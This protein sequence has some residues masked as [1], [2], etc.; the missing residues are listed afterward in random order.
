MTGEEFREWLTLMKAQGFNKE[1]C[2]EL[3]GRKPQW[4]SIS[5]D[6][7]TDKMAALACAAVLHGIEPFTTAAPV[8]LPR[9]KSSGRGRL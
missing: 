5:Q 9:R 3:L 2:A 6:T 7:G 8:V 1:A 4:V